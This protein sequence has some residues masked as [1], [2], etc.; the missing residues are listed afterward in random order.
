MARRR[1]RKV[2]WNPTNVPATVRWSVRISQRPSPRRSRSISHNFTTLLIAALRPPPRPESRGDRDDGVIFARYSSCARRRRAARAAPRPVV[3]THCILPSGT[4]A[5]AQPDLGVRQLEHRPEAAHRM[6]SRPVDGHRHALRFARRHHVVARS[7]H[8]FADPA[9]LR[10]LLRGRRAQAGPVR[11]R[12]GR[13]LRS[14]VRSD[15]QRQHARALHLLGNH[16]GVVVPAG[17]PLR[18]TRIEQA[19]RDAGSARH[20]RRW[21]GDAGGHHR[22]RPGRWVVQPVRRRRERPGR[23]AARS[24]DRVDPHRRT[25]QIGHRADALLAARCH[26]RA[27]A[28][29]WLPAR[30][31]DGQGRYLPGRAPRSGFR[32]L[33]SVARHGHQPR[34]AVDD[35][36][37]LASTP[38]LRPQTHSGVRHGQPAGLPDG[39]G[40]H[41][42]REGHAGRSDDGDRARDVQG[43]P[44]HGGRH[45]RPHHRHSRHS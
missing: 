15:H 13:V 2:G 1:P 30:R 36:G 33:R 24:G 21:S 3:G 22:P 5:T 10:P 31:R 17:R 27:D 12:D 32:G 14:H 42:I 39:P 26:G 23:L 20:H 45:H 44:V 37:R 7:G 28:G 6:G 16:D 41:R 25:E 18:R 34:I 11:R 38:R 29:Q 4:G 9:V 35:S 40:R 43:H 19:R 8:R